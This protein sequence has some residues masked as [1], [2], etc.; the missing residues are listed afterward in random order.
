MPVVN[1][2]KYCK[3]LNLAYEKKYAYPA[4]NVSNMETASAV[5]TGLKK[6]N[7][8]GIIQ[9]SIG[10]AAHASGA[11]IKDSVLGAVALSEYV[12]LVAEKY[13]VNVALHRPLQKL[14]FRKIF[15]SIN[16]W[17]REEKKKRFEKSF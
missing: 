7:S 16:R 11:E 6:A 4:F 10:G 9:V 3:M 1:Y 13:D 17:N 14:R 2:E 5:L 15:N 12:H 8:D